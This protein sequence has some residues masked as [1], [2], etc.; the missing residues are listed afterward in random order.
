VLISCSGDDGCHGGE[1][2]NAFEWMNKNE[3]TDET[4]AIY[5]ARGHDNGE[6]CSAQLKCDNCDHTTKKCFAVDQHKVYH[7]DEYGKV[8]GE[9]AMM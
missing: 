8:S 2:Y 6:A 3:V 1:A 4:C 7:T 9:A 5:R